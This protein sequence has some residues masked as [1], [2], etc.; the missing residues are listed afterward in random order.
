MKPIRRVKLLLLPPGLLPALILLAAVSICI[1]HFP[2]TRF[3]AI[4]Y[5]HPLQGFAVVIDPGH[6]G[7]DPGVHHNGA[8]TEKEVVLAVGLTLQHLLEQA[9]ADVVMTRDTEGDVS[10]HLPESAGSRYQRDVNSRI[11]IINESGADL[12][13]SLHIDSIYDSDVRGAI[14][15]YCGSRPE[16]KMLA[17]IVQK[18]INPVVSVN[19]LPGQYIHQHIKENSSYKVLNCAEIP[20]IIVEMGFMTSPADRELL[21]QEQYRQKL[22]QAIFLGIVEYTYSR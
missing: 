12:F 14:V 22:A 21:K 6:G 8:F 18:N 10:Q 3:A 2:A 9:G 16:N 13:V 20:G 17:E 1:T 11:K 7:I 19:P 15:Y 4:Y 5:G